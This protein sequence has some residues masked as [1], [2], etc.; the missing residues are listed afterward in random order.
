MPLLFSSQH[1]QALVPAPGV[2]LDLLQRRV[3]FP[4]LRHAVV[5]GHGQP[6]VPE[7]VGDRAFRYGIL[8]RNFLCQT[9]GESLPIGKI[10]LALGAAS[11]SPSLPRRIS[12]WIHLN[13]RGQT[14]YSLKFYDAVGEMEGALQ[15]TAL[16]R[17]EDDPDYFGWIKA[18]G[19]MLVRGYRVEVDGDT[20]IHLEIYESETPAD[21]ETSS[22]KR[23]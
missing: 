6:A 11:D 14:F 3:D 4:N 2:V 18:N 7:D 15:P 5:P 21:G 10:D 12:A 17:H 19:D 20:Q 22:K 8:R 13:D 1:C 9:P 16:K 23:G